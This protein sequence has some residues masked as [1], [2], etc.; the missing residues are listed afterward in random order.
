MCMPFGSR[1][2]V[3]PHET[4]EVTRRAESNSPSY[5]RFDLGAIHTSSCVKGRREQSTTLTVVGLRL[6][7][8]STPLMKRATLEVRG[9]MWQNNLGNRNTTNTSTSNKADKRISN[10][11]YPVE[12]CTG[13]VHR[14]HN[15]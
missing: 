11:H 8:D 6:K 13:R 1:N 3:I 9:F 12:G 15:A 2:A 10:G 14:S 4:T 5:A 7:L